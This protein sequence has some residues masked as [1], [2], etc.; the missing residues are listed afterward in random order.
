MRFLLYLSPILAQ[1]RPIAK[2][3]SATQGHWSMAMSVL[4]QFGISNRRLARNLRRR[5]KMQTL[6]RL[7]IISLHCIIY[8]FF[9]FKSQP[10]VELQVRS[11]PTSSSS[12]TRCWLV[13]TASWRTGSLQLEPVNPFKVFVLFLVCPIWLPLLSNLFYNVIE[14]I[15]AHIHPVYSPQPLDH[16][17]YALTT[18]P[19]LLTCPFSI[20][21]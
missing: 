4:S 19:W 10:R 21:N 15:I 8:L 9:V 20:F 6:T 11:L 14:C 17:P 16:E 13:S 7:K 1:C 12:S 18:R 5:K 3:T 2:L